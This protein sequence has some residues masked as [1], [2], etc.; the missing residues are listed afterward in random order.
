[1]RLV[2][3]SE[4]G[5]RM[6]DDHPLSALTDAEVDLVRKLHELHGMSYGLL[7][8]KF[9]VSKAAIA[10]ICRYERRAQFAVRFKVIGG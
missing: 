6:G 4:T 1:M 9:E 3:I 8:Q 2:A 10:K 7:A 5:R